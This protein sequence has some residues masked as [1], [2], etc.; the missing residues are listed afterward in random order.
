MSLDVET[1]RRNMG[2]D[3]RGRQMIC[4]ERTYSS[5][6]AWEE[7]RAM[8]A[9]VVIG[10]EYIMTILIDFQIELASDHVESKVMG[11]RWNLFLVKE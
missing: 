5:A 6:L 7:R 10:M 8:M 9:V 1:T 2:V 4:M 11:C 3:N